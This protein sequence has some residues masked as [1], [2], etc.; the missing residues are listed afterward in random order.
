[1]TWLGDYTAGDVIDFKFTSRRFSTGAPFTLSGSVVPVL[2]CSKSN[3]TTLSTAGITVTADFASTTGLNHVRINTAAD[4]TFYADGNQFDVVITNGTVDS[5]S[6]VGEVVGRFTLGILL[7]PTTPGRK[8][9]VTTGGEAGIDWA[10]IGNPTAIVNLSNTTVATVTNTVPADV[11]AVNGSPV[12]LGSVLDANIVSIEGDALVA[13]T[14]G[15]LPVDL[16][17]IDSAVINTSTAQIGVNVV[18]MAAN[19]VT[20][21]A[22][23]ADAGTELATAL[24]K[25]DFTGITGEATRSVL[26]A[27]RKLMNKWSISGNTLTVTK[28]D[29][30]TTAYTQTIT[31]NSSAAPITA[32]DTN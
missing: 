32:I 8:L 11:V 3:G 18:S 13:H 24:L 20:A 1:M 12:T 19:T 22:L 25:L 2:A 4:P 17:N 30:S 31:T 9:D 7:K 29:D 14:G 21:S 23:A 26:N 15:M 28:E 16:K 27:L 10:N 6:V 5:V